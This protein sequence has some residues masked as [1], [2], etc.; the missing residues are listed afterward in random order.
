M[1]VRLWNKLP[2]GLLK[3]KPRGWSKLDY[4]VMHLIVS[5]AREQGYKCAH[6]NQTRGLE[7]EHDH[8][9][10]RGPQGTSIPYTVYN[11]R[12]LVC[13]PCNWDIGMYEAEERGEYSNWP[14]RIRR[15]S[16]REYEE[17][18]YLYECRV[19]SLI[20]TELEERLGSTN[21]W[22]RRNLLSKFDDWREWG[23]KKKKTYP[24]YWGFD[25]IKDKKYGRFRTLKQ[26]QQFFRTLTAMVRYVVEH[27]EYEPSEKFFE[28]IFWIK[29]ILEDVRPIIETRIRAIDSAEG[30]PSA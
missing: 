19:G 17:Y 3:M 13:R 10:V 28:I 11:V 27:P 8:Y 6:C 2:A 14:D 23:G 22:R 1:S 16:D 18:I 26:I 24:W 21:Y 20:E 4:N 29:P 5:L 15:V 12:G 25:E 7:I 9:P 30:A